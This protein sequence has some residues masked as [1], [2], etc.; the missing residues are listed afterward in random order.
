MRFFLFGMIGPSKNQGSS[1]NPA[2]DEA[3]YAATRSNGPVVVPCTYCLPIS[4]APKTSEPSS[5]SI[6]NPRIRRAGLA[7]LPG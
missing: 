5:S 3:H 4:H 6:S 2:P 7:P 1:G